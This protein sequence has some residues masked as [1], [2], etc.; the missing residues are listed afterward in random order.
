MKLMT[1]M[2]FEIENDT[3]ADGIYATQRS[4]VLPEYS[5][6]IKSYALPNRKKQL[7]SY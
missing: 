4:S 3:K 5:P 7:K 6:F 1:M 2:I